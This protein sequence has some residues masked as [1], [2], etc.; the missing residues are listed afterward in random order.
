MVV[1]GVT[2]Q[3]CVHGF[4]CAGLVRAEEEEPFTRYILGVTLK[5][6]W[7]HEIRSNTTYVNMYRGRLQH[8]I[9]RQILT[10][11]NAHHPLYVLDK[12]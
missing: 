1:I 5:T 2:L 9:P 6:I 12:L 7:N 11:G 8:R 3:I 10:Q 4:A